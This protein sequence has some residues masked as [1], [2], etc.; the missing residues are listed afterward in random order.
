[1][2]MYVTEYTKINVTEDLVKASYELRHRNTGFTEDEWKEHWIN[3][4]NSVEAEEINSL[5]GLPIERLVS[6]L[7][8]ISVHSWDTLRKAPWHVEMENTDIKD[9]EIAVIYRKFIS[10]MSET[11]NMSKNR[12][13]KLLK[14]AGLSLNITSSIDKAY[15]LEYWQYD[16]AYHSDKYFGKYKGTCK[17]KELTCKEIKKDWFGL[18]AKRVVDVLTCEEVVHYGISYTGLY[19]CSE[20]VS[21]ILDKDTGMFNWTTEQVIKEYKDREKG[22]CVCQ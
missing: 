9:R 12:V 14:R 3:I 16:K 13:R 15:D 5:T 22:A 17:D 7:E 6:E 8:V 11:Y 2:M 19:D 10:Y 20:L 1:M 21:E 18:A 4:L